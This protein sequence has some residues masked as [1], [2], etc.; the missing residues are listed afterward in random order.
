MT[1][2]PRLRIFGAQVRQ[3]REAQGL[4][5]EQLAERAGIGLR[6]LVRV[7]AGRAS[8]SLVWLLAVASG[9]E[10]TVAELVG[11]LR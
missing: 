5:H 2:D 4:T 8:P 7:E 9:L 3:L 11:D 10:A 6:Q 1:P